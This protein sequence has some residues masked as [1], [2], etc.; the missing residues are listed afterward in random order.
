MT[1]QDILDRI[2]EFNEQWPNARWSFGHI[3][4]ED[5]NLTHR[6][7]DCCLKRK[8]VWSWVE[9]SKDR[10]ADEVLFRTTV[11]TIEFLQWLRTMPEELLEEAEEMYHGGWPD[12][13]E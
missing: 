9:H 2:E 5:L 1:G 10:L 8:M 3:V 13:G 11:A 4:L 7:I 12:S 6:H